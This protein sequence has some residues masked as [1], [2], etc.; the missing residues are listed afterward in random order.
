MTVFNEAKF[1]QDEVMIVR[2]ELN[3]QRDLLEKSIEALRLL[4]DA[5]NGPPLYEYKI[6][7]NEAMAASLKI[8]RK[9]ESR[10]IGKFANPK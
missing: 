8:L 4:Y 1:W 2:A 7:W 6:E 9:V 3:E 10:G 5:Q